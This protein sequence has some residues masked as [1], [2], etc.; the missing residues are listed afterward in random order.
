MA[1]TTQGAPH[2]PQPDNDPQPD[3]PRPDVETG[4]EWFSPEKCQEAVD[5]DTE[6]GR[7]FNRNLSRPTI[8]RYSRAMTEDRWVFT[9]EP[10]IMNGEKLLDGFHRFWA[11]IESGV[12]QWFVV[13]RGIEQKAFHHID[14]GRGRSFRDTCYVEGIDQHDLVAS[15]CGFLAGY[16]K[17]KRFANRG[18]EDDDR[19]NA[20]KEFELEITDL[21]GRYS[22]RHVKSLKYIT[23][24]LLLAVHVILNRRD[25]EKALDY[26]DAMTGVQNDLDEGHPAI[27]FKEY[28]R[29]NALLDDRPSD[30]MARVGSG[31]L[32]SW[33]RWLKGEPVPKFKTP[34]NT[35]DPN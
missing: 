30:Y 14:H 2:A 1:K 20:Y 19:W 21:K 8:F 16:Q 25:G 32:D 33:N 28:V 5:S 10:I 22:K 12:G 4:V 34:S 15:A 6:T 11:V 26:M 7:A 9:G 35:P 29:K 31:L 17:T 24:G 27:A 3:R 23:P 13:V 18:L